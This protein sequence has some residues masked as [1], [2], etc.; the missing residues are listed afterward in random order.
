MTMDPLGRVL[1]EAASPVTQLKR[2][3]KSRIQGVG[4][5]GGRA[6]L[7]ARSAKLQWAADLTWRRDQQSEWQARPDS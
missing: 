7:N 3:F 6:R 1:F 4:R 5:V 2:A